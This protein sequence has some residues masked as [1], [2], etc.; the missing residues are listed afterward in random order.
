[1]KAPKI[2]IDELTSRKHP[3]DFSTDDVEDVVSAILGNYAIVIDAIPDD[4]VTRG[5]MMEMLKGS[6]SLFLYIQEVDELFQV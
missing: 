4:P 2:N 5:A 3:G 6:L 1:M